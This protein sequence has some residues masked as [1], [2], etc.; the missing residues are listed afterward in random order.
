MPP[1]K[2]PRGP[3][4][5][6]RFSNRSDGTQA[7]KV[8]NVG[9]HPD[10]QQGDRQALESAQRTAP[11]PAGRT[12]R[13]SATPPATAGAGPAGLSPDFFDDPTNRPMEPVTTGLP[14][15]LGAGPEVLQNQFGEAETEQEIL[16][17]AVADVFGNQ[18]ALEAVNQL[19][20]ARVQ[21]TEEAIG[22]P[23][24][25]DLG[26]SETEGL[27]EGGEGAPDDAGAIEF[28]APEPEP[29]G[30]DTDRDD[31]A[32]DLPPDEDSVAPEGVPLGGE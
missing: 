25:L 20:Q 2:R 3:S 28:S 14:M 11:L 21:P 10:L 23:S 8:P 12:P 17:E 22:A 6:G 7:I 29:G 27:G 31:G 18:E 30:A 24:G 32:L 1:P 15:G 13:P 9:S 16:L 4:A 5:P 26:L 19:R